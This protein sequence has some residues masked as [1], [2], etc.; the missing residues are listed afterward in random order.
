VL[1]GLALE[2]V[3]LLKGWDRPSTVAKSWRSS[4]RTAQTACIQVSRCRRKHTCSS[5]ERR[6]GRPMEEPADGSA[7]GMSHWPKKRAQIS[8]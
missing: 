2:T 8:A 4:A 7:Q 3:H 1:Q 6:A 5:T